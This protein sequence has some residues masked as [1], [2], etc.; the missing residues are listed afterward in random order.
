MPIPPWLLPSLALCALC[1]PLFALRMLE[2]FVVGGQALPAASF[3]YLTAAVE[4]SIPMLLVVV[5]AHW[6]SPLQAVYS[7]ALLGQLLIM[8]LLALR[9]NSLIPV[10]AGV[11]AALQQ[12]AL[13]WWLTPPDASSALLQ[14][15]PM[16]ARS[17]LVLMVGV[18]AG[19]VA[20]E[21]VTGSIGSS[22]RKEYTVIGDVVNVASRIEGL[23]KAYDARLLVSGEV[24]RALAGQVEGGE[25]LGAVPVKGRVEPVE[26]V[27]LA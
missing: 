1:Y 2:R 27:R 8:V 15:T 19:F 10:F 11:V 3:A 4:V 17:A 6:V 13:W 16:V 23:T 14:P 25:V 24:W 18:V 21:V 7:P 26:L 5:I 20:G 22:A 9:L 12:L